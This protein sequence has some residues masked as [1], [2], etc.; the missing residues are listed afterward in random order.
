MSAIVVNNEIVHYEVLGRGP[1]IVFLHGW[2]G[3]WRYWVRTMQAVSSRYRCYA[4]DLWGFGDTS[5]RPPT[6]YTLDAQAELV[7]EFLDALG[8]AKVAIVGHGLGSAVALRFAAQNPDYVA[9]TMCISMPLAGATINPRMKQSSLN[10]ANTWLANGHREVFDETSR[11]DP[12]AFTASMQDFENIDLRRD[13][14][15]AAQPTLLVH[16][17]ADQAI[18]A[19]RSSWLP[20]DDFNHVHRVLIPELGHFPMLEDPTK[21]NRLLL[22]FLTS[23]P[24]ELESLT[25]KE[26]WKRRVR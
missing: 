24:D 11:L 26:E 7:R 1:G 18:A 15:T 22:D 21:F 17:E 19:P 13:L 20:G 9:R 8:V 16:G 10:D 6:E 25:L 12:Q 2:L 3:S 4:V 14:V 5:H 23:A